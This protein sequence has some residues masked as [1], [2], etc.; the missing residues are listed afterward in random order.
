MGMDMQ[1][2]S[3]PNQDLGTVSVAAVLASM[4]VRPGMGS[5]TP[6]GQKAVQAFNLAEGIDDDSPHPGVERRGQLLVRLVVAVQ[7]QIRGRDTG[8]QR[9]GQLA[10]GGHVEPHALLVR[11]PGHGPTEKGLGGVVGTP[12]EGPHGL[13]AAAAKV[14]L[15]VH[16]QG[17]AELFSQPHRVHL[18]QHQLPLRSQRGR[19]WQQAQG[20]GIGRVINGGGRRAGPCRVRTHSDR[21][22][23][24]AI[25]TSPARAMGGLTSTPGR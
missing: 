18:T 25:P 7:Q 11:H 4:V 5:T 8:P 20:Y 2:R 10:A 21:G 19:V 9:Q 24:L 13:A 17:G 3:D 6:H 23:L 1:S 12:G 15:V 22:P 16:E 14:F